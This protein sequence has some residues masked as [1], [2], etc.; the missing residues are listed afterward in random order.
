MEGN[1]QDGLTWKVQAREIQND[2]L[3]CLLGPS[4]SLKSDLRF[5]NLCR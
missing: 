1:W 5:L 2:D 3:Q 4:I